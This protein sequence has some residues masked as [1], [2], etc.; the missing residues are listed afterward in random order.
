[1]NPPPIKPSRCLTDQEQGQLVTILNY[2]YAA[3]LKGRLF[4]LEQ[5]ID[6]KGVYATV[7]LSKDDRT[8]YYPV[9]AR[10]AHSASNLTPQEGGLL[11][12]DYIDAYF[13]EFLREDETVLLPIDWT[14][15]SCEGVD[16]Q[17]R[18]E[19]RN[20]LREE[21]AEEFLAGRALS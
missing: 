3:Y 13:G 7:L 15:F 6:D 18:G 9:E 2:K 19:I 10:L 11:L 1:M 21:Q 14:D 5:H 4:S 8:F 16:F 17:M 20:L 12:L